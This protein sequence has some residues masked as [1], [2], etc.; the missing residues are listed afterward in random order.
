MARTIPRIRIEKAKAEYIRSGNGA[1][2]ILAAGLSK[3]YAYHDVDDKNTLLNTVKA[4]TAKELDNI[5]IVARL[6]RILALKLKL[7]ESIFEDAVNDPSLPR[8]AKLQIINKTKDNIDLIIKNV[9]LL[10]G[11][12]TENINISEQERAAR[13]SRIKGFLNQAVSTN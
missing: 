6:K 11:E 4:E 2:A 9:R 13:L 8:A 5:G 12:S 1:K 10:E 7:E 3:S